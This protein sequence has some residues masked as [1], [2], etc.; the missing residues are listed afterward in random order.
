MQNIFLFQQNRN[1]A[2]IFI[3]EQKNKKNNVAL[4]AFRSSKRILNL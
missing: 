1:T 4:R 3:T 2:W